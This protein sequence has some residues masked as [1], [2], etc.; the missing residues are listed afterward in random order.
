MAIKKTTVY[1]T[2][3]N[4][5]FD[6]LLEA[7]A[8]ELSLDIAAVAISQ[9]VHNSPEVRLLCQKIAKNYSAFVDVF[10]Q[11]KL[12]GMKRAAAAKKVEQSK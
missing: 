6:T 10:H 3:D 12:N 2:R 1:K 7:E 8:H 4:E 9:G 11:I 5:D